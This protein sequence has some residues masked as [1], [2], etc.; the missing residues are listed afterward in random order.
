M[1]GA[2]DLLAALAE[3]YGAPPHRL[4]AYA[5]PPEEQ[6]LLALT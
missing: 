6:V 2:R 3:V 1:T 5:A 4:R